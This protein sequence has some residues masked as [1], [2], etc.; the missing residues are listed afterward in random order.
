[1]DIERLDHVTCEDDE[2]EV[3]WWEGEVATSDILERACIECRYGQ[4][5]DPMAWACVRA[6]AASPMA[7]R[8]F[9]HSHADAIV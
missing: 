2:I 8:P 6:W 1:M 5:G 4:V 3:R 7:L 9:L